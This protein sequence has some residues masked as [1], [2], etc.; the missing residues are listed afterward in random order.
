MA[1]LRSSCDQKAF[2]MANLC[3]R[4]DELALLGE[5]AADGRVS[6]HS[7]AESQC[8]VPS[9]AK[10]EERQHMQS[11]RTSHRAQLQG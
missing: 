11:S 8:G 7:H 9:A 2:F 1:G 4:V 10:G 6:A 3:Y 5:A